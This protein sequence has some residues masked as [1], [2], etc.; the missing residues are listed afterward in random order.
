MHAVGTGGFDMTG[1]SDPWYMK[2]VVDYILAQN[3]HLVVDADRFY[4][5]GGINPR[6][7]LFSWSL[8]IG[9]MILQPVLGENAV[10]WSMLALPAVY[11]ALTIWP[12]AAIARDHF[13]KAAGV[14]AA[15][16]IAFMPAHV[17]HSTWGLA[18]HDSFVMLFIVLGFMFY[19]R[20]VKYAGSERLVRTTSIHPLDMLRAMGAVARERKYAMSNAV[21]AGV[22]FGA[23]SLGW[24]G[25]V[26]G[27]A[28]L[29]LAYAAQV[30]LNMFRRRD[31][32]IL[33]TLFL[34]ML[35]TNLLIA[36][37]FYA[38]P[39]MNLMLNATGS[40]TVPLHPLVHCGYHLHHDRIP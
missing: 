40:A 7:P 21:L 39:Q 33:S 25:F 31:S 29:F 6:P 9:A 13:G 28:I 20:A 36:M 27:P 16:L 32:T 4:P 30:A 34:T 24:K 17:T 22:A 37:P 26:A 14:I 3:A 18:D 11:G 10:W 38:H 19:L 35:L 5:I 12:V 1:G 2:R 15:W 8:A 23:A